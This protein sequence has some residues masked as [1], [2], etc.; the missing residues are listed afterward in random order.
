MVDSMFLNCLLS[1][2]LRIISKTFAE[3]IGNANPYNLSK[4]SA[5]G[6]F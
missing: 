2:R 3:G 1:K 5:R 6:S 4:K